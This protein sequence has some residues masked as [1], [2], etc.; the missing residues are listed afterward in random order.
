MVFKKGL[1][2]A[3]NTL[4]KSKITYL[5]VIPTLMHYSGS[6]AEFLTYHL[7]SGSIYD[8]YLYIPTI[9]LVSFQAFILAPFQAFLLA[10]YLASI[11]TFYL[12]YI[13]TAFLSGILSGICSDILSA[14]L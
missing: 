8:I 7:E 9:Y 3:F 10:F 14:S 11:L 12:D 6:L 13:L 1:V 4:Y 2:N 5:K